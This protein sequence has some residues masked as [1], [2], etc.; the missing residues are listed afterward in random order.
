MEVLV[1]W[2]GGAERSVPG[3]A[4]GEGGRGTRPLTCPD[5][6][7][8]ARRPWLKGL[9]QTS[10]RDVGPT[11][12]AAG[13]GTTGPRRQPR[14]PPPQKDPPILRLTWHSRFGGRSPP[15]PKAM[16]LRLHNPLSPALP[17]SLVQCRFGCI[18][19]KAVWGPWPFHGN[20]GGAPLLLVGSVGAG[21]GGR[22]L[23]CDRPSRA[24]APPH[25]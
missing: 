4:Q 18:G 8:A 17:L 10:R 20:G 23:G 25:G 6:D 13:A 21:V 15:P 12:G 7:A 9:R 24:S 14:P 19:R 16:S 5:A 1:L 22:G 3:P 11:R 2:G